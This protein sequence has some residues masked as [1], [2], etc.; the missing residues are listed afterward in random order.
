M[1]RRRLIEGKIFGEA[2]GGAAFAGAGEQSE[3]SAAGGIGAC[4]A[5]AEIVIDTS[6]AERFFDERLVRADV[7]KK[8]RDAIEGRAL[9]S[10][11]AD[12]AG[13]LD[14]LETLAGGGE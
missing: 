6:A 1:E 4:R 2:G 5:A 7:A 14:A 12:A 8:D 11:C 13:D 3:K 10:E 9:F